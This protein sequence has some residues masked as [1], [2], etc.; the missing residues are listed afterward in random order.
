[1]KHYPLN[2]TRLLHT[3]TLSGYNT[4]TAS[5]KLKSQHAVVRHYIE[6]TQT[7]EILVL[8]GFLVKRVT[9]FQIWSLEGSLCS[10]WA[11]LTGLIGKCIFKK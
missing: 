9:V 7:L 3:E 1:M 10:T 6:P 5:L 2:V 8:D 4:C 11:A